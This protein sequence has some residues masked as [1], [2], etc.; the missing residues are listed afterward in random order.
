MDMEFRP[1]YLFVRQFACNLKIP[2][3]NSAVT[4]FKILNISVADCQI[5]WWWIETEPLNKSISLNI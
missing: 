2:L 3:R 4:P 1:F 5:F